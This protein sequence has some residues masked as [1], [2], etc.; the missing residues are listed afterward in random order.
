MAPGT[1]QFLTG[2]RKKFPVHIS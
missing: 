2:G 1:D